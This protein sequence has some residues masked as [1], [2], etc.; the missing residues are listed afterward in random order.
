M[1]ICLVCLVKSAASE[2]SQLFAQIV[3]KFE[4]KSGTLF[5]FGFNALQKIA[6]NHVHW[7]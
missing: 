6:S 3:T 4:E 5:L 1:Y 2:T 7:Q